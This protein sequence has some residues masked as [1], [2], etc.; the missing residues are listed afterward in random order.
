[1]KKKPVVLF[2]YYY[3][4]TSVASAQEKKKEKTKEGDRIKIRHGAGLVKEKG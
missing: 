1:M 4:L 2:V 3:D